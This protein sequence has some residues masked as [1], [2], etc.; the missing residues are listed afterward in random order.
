VK[1]SSASNALKLIQQP[2][3]EEKDMLKNGDED[4]FGEGGAR[5]VTERHIA[6]IL[7]HSGESLIKAVS[8]PGIKLWRPAADDSAHES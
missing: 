6:V 3:D 8:W 7:Q 4:R 1:G 2:L 5:N